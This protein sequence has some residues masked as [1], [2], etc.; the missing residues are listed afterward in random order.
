[1][2]KRTIKKNIQPIFI[3]DKNTA[4]TIKC[5]PRDGGHLALLRDWN[6]QKQRTISYK[7]LTSISI[8]VLLTSEIAN[9]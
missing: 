6:A 5:K 3:N 4:F 8:N 7:K 9:K 2:G 1:M